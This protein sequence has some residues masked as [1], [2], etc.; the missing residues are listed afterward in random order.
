MNKFLGIGFIGKKGI[1]LKFASGS[2]LA[3]ANFSLS[4]PREYSKGD[5]KEYD[6]INCVAFKGTAEFL[7]NNA[8]K[9]KK[10][11]VE[12]SIQTRNYDAKDGT[13]KYITEILVSKANVVEWNNEGQQATNFNENQQSDFTEVTDE[14]S[15]IPF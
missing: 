4:I 3:I 1:E 7:A 12:G 11:L 9:I 10:L 14:N 13:K 15:E 2:G 5:K 6:F 8:D